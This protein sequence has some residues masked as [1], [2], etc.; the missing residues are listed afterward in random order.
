M[1]ELIKAPTQIPVPSGKIIDEYVG[2]RQLW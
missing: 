1:P 2:A